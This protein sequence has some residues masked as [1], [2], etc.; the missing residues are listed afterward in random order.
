M[1]ELALDHDERDA[2]AGHFDGVRVPK[3]MWCQAAAH[4]CPRGS[5]TKLRACGPRRPCAPAGRAG[6]DA[7]QRADLQLG[8]R[9]QPWLELLPAPVVHADLSAATAPAT[10][11]EQRAAARVEICLPEREGFVDAQPCAPITRR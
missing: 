11:H 1:A 7:E 2:F 9:R 5:V 3:L 10:A 6:G 8:A 4:A